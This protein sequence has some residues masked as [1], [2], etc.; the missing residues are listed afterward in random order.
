MT[1]DDFR[2]L[3]LALPGAEEG[4]HGGHPDFRLNGRIFATLG[5]PDEKHGMVQLDPTDQALLVRDHPRA[6]VPATGA[7]GARGSTMVVLRLAPKRVVAVAL[8]AAW[9]KRRS[10]RKKKQR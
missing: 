10:G 6:F 1:Y 2:A 7:W 5:Y 9:E 8:E 4:E 3:A